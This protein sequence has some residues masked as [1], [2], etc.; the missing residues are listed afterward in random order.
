MSSR[1]TAACAAA[2]L[3]IGCG[4]EKSEQSTPAPQLS[5]EYVDLILTGGK[6]LTVDSEFSIHDTVIVDDGLIVATGG[7]E[8]LESYDAAETVDLGGKVLMP[9]FIDSHTHI[10]GRPIRFI[11]LSEVSSIE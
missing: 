6:V 9:G 1:L 4:S 8:L 11:E 2:A 10:R 3:L 7:S 5:A